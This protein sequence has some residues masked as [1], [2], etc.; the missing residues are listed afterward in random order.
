M[1]TKLAQ[2][3]VARYVKTE[4]RPAASTLGDLGD[5]APKKKKGCT[6]F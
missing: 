1:F 3:M 6:L 5:S 2:A 4:T